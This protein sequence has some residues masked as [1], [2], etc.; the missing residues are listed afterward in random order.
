MDTY[1][2]AVE[3]YHISIAVIKDTI[4]KSFLLLDLLMM[5]ME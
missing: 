2:N 3:Q 5:G 4:Q 1:L